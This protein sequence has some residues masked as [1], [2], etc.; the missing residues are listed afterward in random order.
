MLTFQLL[1]VFYLLPLP[2]AVFWLLPRAKTQQAAVRVPFYRELEGLS[3]QPSISGSQRKI[4]LSTLALIW[5]ALVA[6]AAQPLWIGDPV[7]LPSSG[8]DLLVAV[9]ISGSMNHED[10]QAQGKL[11]PR[12]FAV[13]AVLSDFIERRQGDRLGLILFGTNAYLQ[14]PLTFDRT[15]V[16]RFLLEAQIG[17]AGDKQTA[18]GDAIGL[19]VKRLRQRPGDRHVVILLTDG[20]NNGGQV[21]PIPAAR[22]ARQENI[23]I[24]TVGVGADQMVQPGIFGSSIGGRKVNPSADLDEESLREIA[25]IT[26]GKY[27]RARDPI[28]LIK[29][30]QLLDELEP[31][32]DQEKSFR[33]Q[34]ALFFWPLGL[35]LL[36]SAL[37]ATALLP[38]REWS[39]ASSPEPLP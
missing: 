5:F 24:Y 22:L 9:D 23:V 20:A 29:I 35:A 13:K 28:E 6:G 26:G 30:Y 31:V 18:I 14:A 19:A 36:L 15:T 38:W 10:M 8:R 16:K 34:K 27:F 1:W 25:A 7:S 3:H 12:I 2:I 39:T 21:N 4:R 37:M 33:P 17:F 32:E 11:I